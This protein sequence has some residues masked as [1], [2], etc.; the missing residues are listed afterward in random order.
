M[1]LLDGHSSH[2]S[3]STIKLAA[4]NQII[5]FVL[6]PNTTHIAQPLDVGCF[7]PL[8]AAWIKYCHDFRAKNP[9]RVVT[10]YDFCHI[11]SQAWFKAMS[12]SNIVSSFKAT[13]V[14]P[15]NRHTF[16]A[17]RTEE[18]VNYAAFKPQNLAERTGLAYIYSSL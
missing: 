16:D 6:P 15:F 12:A 1:L 2:Y 13:G 14:C 10:R 7:S 18:S 11:F 9:G 4:E 17:T 5:V 8:K 3:P